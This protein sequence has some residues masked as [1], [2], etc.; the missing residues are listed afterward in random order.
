MR[1][2][3]VIFLCP[4]ILLSGDLWACSLAGAI[5]FKPSLER[6]DQHPGP[7]QFDPDAKGSYWEGVPMP[8]VQ[9]RQ[10]WRGTS[11]DGSSCEDAGSIELEI[12][13]PEHSTYSIEEFAFYFRVKEGQ[14]P[15]GIFPSVPLT[16][17]VEGERARLWLHWLD[18]HPDRQVPLD[19]E[20]ELFLVAKDL[21]IGPSAVFRV[22]AAAGRP[23]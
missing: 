4:C 6:W 11:D 5:P 15:Y 19:L 7:K 13:L 14:N 9:V 3:P 18:G 21:S 8:V 16:G 22:K 20:V 1:L 10:V 2:I 17:L 23:T 12:T